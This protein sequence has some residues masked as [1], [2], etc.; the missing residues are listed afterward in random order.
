MT[1]GGIASGLPARPTFGGMHLASRPIQHLISLP[2][3]MA[4]SFAVLEGRQP[5][6]WFAGHDPEG[7]PLGSGG[8]TA[9][10]LVEAWR[11]SDSGLGFTEWLRAGRKLILH[12]GGQSRR[13]PAYAATGKI[14]MPIPVFRW[15]RGQRL[16]QSLLDV[17]LGDYQ[18]ILRQAPD[19]VAVMVT[20]GDVALRFDAALPALPT[21]DVL[22][23]GM[24]TTP[25]TA[26]HFGVFFCHRR[27]PSRL[28]FF[29][30]KPCV[31]RIRALSEDHLFLVDTGMWLLSA[32]AV[33]VLLRRCGWNDT[34]Q[35]F[36]NGRARRYELY[37]DFGLGLGSAPAVEDPELRSLTSAVVPLP[38]PEFHHF[39]TTRQMIESLSALQNRELDQRRLG[40]ALA[41]GS[42][43]D[44][45][46]QNSRVE[47]A[48]HRETNHTLWIENCVI[49]AGWQ[50]AHGHVLTGIPENAWD[51]VL[52]PEVCLDFVPVGEGS[53]W[54]V[55]F[56]GLDDPFAGPVGELTSRW[57]GE[58]AME[59]FRR[60]GLNPRVAGVGEQDDLQ[61]AALFPVLER[62]AIDG[63]FLEWLTGAPTEA[64]PEFQRRWLEARRLS[65]QELQAEIHLGRLFAQRSW[66]RSMALRSVLEHRAWSVFHRLDLE[67]TASACAATTVELPELTDADEPLDQVHGT[68]FRSALMR[69]RGDAQ[70]RDEEQR[71]FASLRDALVREA[72]LAPVKPRPN[73]V[74]DQ[75][76][77]ARCPVRFDLAGGWTDTPPYCLEHGGAVVNVGVNLNGQPPMQVFARLCTQ[78]RIVL[79][80]I[81]QGSEEVVETYE[82]LASYAEP[83]SA[84]ALAKAGAGLAGFLPRFHATG[85]YRSLREQLCDFGGGL[86]LTFLS[87][88]PKGSGLGTSSILAAT[89]LAALGEVCGLAWDRSALF[90]RT[91]VLEQMITTGGGWQDQAGGLFPGLKWIETA[92]GLRQ[93]PQVR[94]LSDHLFG[95]AQANRRILLYYTGVTRMAKGILGEIVRGIFLNSP[96]RLATLEEISASVP[97]AAMALSHRDYAALAES[98]RTTWRLKQQLDH[99]TNPSEI[100]AILQAVEDDLAAAMLPGAGGGGYLLM[101]ARDDDAGER[102]RR[103]LT[104]RPPNRRARFVDFSISETGL[105]VT[106]S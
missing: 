35:S 65:A 99:G 96:S 80:S 34:E 32:R 4:E 27:D 3:R 85:G 73:V 17:Q 101:L 13:L 28:A 36:G 9:H 68:M 6:E 104:E 71:A 30:Q 48:L 40:N 77:W 91:L 37:A 69:H 64:H 20:S 87:A 52:R 24:W 78:P 2:P 74:E 60:R 10:L 50:L 98:I 100:R 75:I 41:M 59:W 31:E 14:L 7:T 83:G 5:P 16:D 105:Q 51:P 18:R 79:R 23:L 95:P 8:G 49:P 43:P 106:R 47:V 25:E 42:H 70:W 46:V 53:R 84:F 44:Q 21:V 66:L 88:V 93:V 97:A 76:V 15:A 92:P 94:W 33:E 39:G 72:Q 86:E 82:Q 102:I 81:D 90:S 54:A 89:V 26:R 38:R 103:R 29:L 22:G 11:G 58:P 45:Y 62:G 55:R 56:Y 61:R 67:S 1:E 57:L 19:D 63:R 12:A